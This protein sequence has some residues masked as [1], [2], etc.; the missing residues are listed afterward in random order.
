MSD[1]T[2]QLGQD[3]NSESLYLWL[4]LSNAYLPSVVV[5]RTKH[6]YGGVIG[7]MDQNIQV[8]PA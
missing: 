1:R 3:S 8:E 5:V 7:T 2:A 4:Q 6:C